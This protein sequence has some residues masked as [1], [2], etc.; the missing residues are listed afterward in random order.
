MTTIAP[1]PDWAPSVWRSKSS[2]KLFAQF[3]QDV[4][5]F[6]ATEG[7]LGKLLKMIP[8][9]EDQPG[10]I[11]GRQNVADHILRKPIKLG[12]KTERLRKMQK[13][14]P[15]RRSILASLVKRANVKE[16]K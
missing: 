1:K 14:E 13:L 7:G 12:K 5:A 10:F 11:S 3:G 9:V 16:G 6:D 4:L 2:L 8:F 15:K